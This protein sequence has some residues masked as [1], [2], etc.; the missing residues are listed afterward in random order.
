MATGFYNGDAV[1]ENRFEP[2]T[3]ADGA[4][5]VTVTFEFILPV[6]YRVEMELRADDDPTEFFDEAAELINYNEGD[7]QG[8]FI[9]EEFFYD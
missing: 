1:P 8:D 4:Q 9:S 2:P 7:F 3:W 6:I 5:M